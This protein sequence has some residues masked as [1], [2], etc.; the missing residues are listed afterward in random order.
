MPS[1]VSIESIDSASAEKP[2]P[3]TKPFKS[4]IIE[5]DAIR[6]ADSF[7]DIFYER[8]KLHPN[9]TYL[10]QALGNRWHEITWLQ[11]YEMAARLVTA[12]REMGLKP[13][14]HVGLISKNCF[15]WIISDLAIMMGG[16][17]SVPF[18]PTLS[19]ADLKEVI[20]L[21]DIKALFVGK[22]EHWEQ[23][24]DAVNDQLITIAFPQFEGNSPIDNCNYSWEDLMSNPPCTNPHKPKADEV[25]TII[26]TSGTTGTP[27]GVMIDYACANE[28]MKHERQS[29]A[30]GVFQGVSERVLSY[31]PLNHIA[32]RVVSEVSPIVAGSEVSFS[33][34]L[35]RFAENLQSVQPTQFFAVPRIWV[36]IQQGI[37]SKLS[38]KKLN[39]ALKIPIIS[40]LLKNKIKR[41]LGLNEVR[42][43]I[44]GAAPLASSLIDWYAK[45]GINIQEVYGATELCGGVTFNT[46]DDITPGSVGRPL[47]GVEIK[48]DTSSDEVLVK[49]PWVMKG[50]YKSPE[51]TAEVLSEDGWYHTGDT[52]RL[53]S[54]GRLTITGRLKDTFKTAKGK[55]IIPVPIE[56]KLGANLFV[57]Q[58]MITGFG[59]VQPIALI[60]LSESALQEEQHV[61]EG[62]I[63]QTLDQVN[64][65]LPS[66][67]RISHA[68]IFPEPWAED[69]GFFT[70]TLKIKRH[71]VDQTYKEHYETWCKQPNGIL[72]ADELFLVSS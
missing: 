54:E 50:Y 69:C 8:A 7:I 62:S 32:E 10:R 65:E 34:S 49:A 22:L 17:V 24:Q 66:Y 46:L 51:K 14:D 33:E 61:I 2:L 42:S 55:F 53:D 1:T 41:G 64:A 18:Y 44:S 19:P 11:A 67:T 5:N 35:D 71:I 47:H 28:V 72:W 38:E 37:L 26:Y 30:Y 21:S 43:A 70:P 39:T 15:P 63:K 45:L 12:M 16:Y 60:N 57:G 59:L 13:G 6:N 23:Q 3:A 36:K 20:E 9:K 29:P 56:H 25:F 52:G 4:S 68:V 58:V 48:I 27:K 40:R 31:L